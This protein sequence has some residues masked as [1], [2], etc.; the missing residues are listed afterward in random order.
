M[1]PYAPLGGR[2]TALKVV[3]G[4]MIALTVGAIVSDAMEIA[5]LQ[6]LIDGQD[7]RDAELVA[8]DDRQ[9]L[10][11]SAQLVLYLAGVVTFIMWLYRAY[12][13]VDVVKP[14]GRRYG[15]GWAI[16]AWFVP[17]LNLF[18]PKQIVNDVWWAGEE[19]P[20]WSLLVWSWWAC[21]LVSG[22]FDRIV[23]TAARR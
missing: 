8:N 12:Q 13:N 14:G 7:V 15:H 16:G 17:I 11:G 3:F 4:L 19:R 5:L 2:L 10:I 23:G 21:F 22:F 9:G 18:R 20:Q 1:V 6:R